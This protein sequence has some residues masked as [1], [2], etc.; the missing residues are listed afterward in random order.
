MAMRNI[1]NY[2]LFQA[3]WLACVGAA[4]EGGMWL[5]P[6]AVLLI[7]GIHMGFIA[8]PES[9]R[10]ELGLLVAVGVL[11]VFADTLV[12]ALGMVTY[13]SSIEAWPFAIAPPWIAALWVLF[14]TLPGHSMG[15]LMGRPW[16]AALLGAIGGPLSFLAGE[17][18]GAIGTGPSPTLTYI[19]LAVEYAICM[20]LLLHFAPAKSLPKQ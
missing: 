2:V 18:L 7:V 1:A 19:V 4:L 20:P 8:R 16:L 5:G 15:W 13:P 10:L 6:L 11:G 12:A 3:G 9:R 14:A 17:R